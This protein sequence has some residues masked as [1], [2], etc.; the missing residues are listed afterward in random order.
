M[1]DTNY[2]ISARSSGLGDMIAQ[3]MHVYW[4]CRETDRQCIVDRTHILH[5][6][7]DE[8]SDNEN[9]FSNLF[10]DCEIHPIE[11]VGELQDYRSSWGADLK[12]KKKHALSK[13]EP[14]IFE[15]YLLTGV[16]PRQKYLTFVGSIDILPFDSLWDF[17][18]IL[19]PKNQISRSLFETIP[20]LRDHIGVHVRHGNGE[21]Y[22]G[23]G[24]HRM[25]ES[26]RN[27]I[28]SL[29]A[30]VEHPKFFLATDSGRVHEWFQRQYGDFTTLNSELP[31]AEGETLHKRRAR[32]D[33]AGAPKS[34]SELLQEALKDMLALS[35]CSHLICSRG[36]SFTRCS[37]AWGN[38]KESNG[39]LRF[40]DAPR[41]S[42]GK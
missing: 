10:E 31:T 24:E 6:A 29:I 26:Y 33:G 3:L 25:F 9:C 18:K 16:K 41:R 4:F 35:M 40:V 37:R 8:A 23:D 21:L 22:D 1:K 30:D 12:G 27:T 39:R 13:F 17:Y 15:T 38:L 14:P 32:R 2:A 7:E 34:T 36:S 28:D 19:Q 11:C 42:K 5:N 20:D